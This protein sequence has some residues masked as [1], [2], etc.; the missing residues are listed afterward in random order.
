M[1]RGAVL[2]YRNPIWCVALSH[3]S[4]RY[5]ECI[6]AFC[7]TRTQKVDTA[8]GLRQN[9]TKSSALRLAVEQV[10]FFDGPQAP[11]QARRIRWG[12]P[13]FGRFHEAVIAIVIAIT[14]QKNLYIA[15]LAV[16]GRGLRRGTNMSDLYEIIT[17]RVI[18]AM[19]TAGKDWRRPWLSPSGGP[20][21][22]ATTGRHYQGV[23]VIN[24]WLRGSNSGLWASYKQ[25]V[26]VGAQVRKGER[27]SMVVYAGV[28]TKEGGEGGEEK[29]T[30]R[31]LR[32]SFVFSAEQVDGYTIP[33]V[34]ALSP[35]ERNEAA[36]Q[37]VTATG[38]SIRHGRGCAYYAPELDYVG[39]PA[40]EAFTATATSTRE[41]SYYSTLLHELAHWTGHKSRIARDLNN[42]FGSQA[43]AAEELIAEMAAAFLCAELG[44]SPAPRPDHAQY[45]NNWLDVLRADKRAIFT[46]ASAATKAA[47]YLRGFGAA[48]VALAA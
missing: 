33:A 19:E 23:N 13:I 4:I 40:R 37:F 45:L 27:G 2:W 38:A 14:F 48:P 31:F 42:R 47:E 29:N 41:E 30:Y 26:S 44:I 3:V 22:N 24:L 10:A 36:E 12:W 16:R 18:E 39:M 25:W 28:G 1:A 5:T 9:G 11:P 17:A 46:A 8:R 6:D 32:S 43:Y 15:V 34:A 7:F 35:V 20:P 21:K